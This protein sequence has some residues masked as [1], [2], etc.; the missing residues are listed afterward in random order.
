MPEPLDPQTR[1]ARKQ[2]LIV[3]SLSGQTVMLDPEEDS[4]LAARAGV[5]SERA[6]VDATA[7]VRGL[8]DAGAARIE[9]EQP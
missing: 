1:I 6:A 4:Y 9:D 2:G 8:L 3:E 5:D 7:F